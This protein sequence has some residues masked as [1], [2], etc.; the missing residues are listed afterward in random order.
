MGQTLESAFG[1]SIYAKG[2]E[3]LHYFILKFKALGITHIYGMG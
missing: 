3:I 2:K 1:N